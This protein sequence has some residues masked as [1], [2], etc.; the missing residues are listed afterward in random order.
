MGARCKLPAVFQC[1][2]ASMRARQRLETTPTA[3][4]LCSSSLSMIDNN[5]RGERLALHGQHALM[6]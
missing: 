4:L 3:Q 6:E 5:S 2:D 1:G